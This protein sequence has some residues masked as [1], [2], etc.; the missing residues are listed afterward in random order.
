MDDR[1]QTPRRQGERRQFREEAGRRDPE[2]V[3]RRRRLGQYVLPAF[4]LLLPLALGAAYRFEVVI[5]RAERA[6][7][8][9]EV[10]EEV[11]SVLAATHFPGLSFPGAGSPAP[12]PP[13]SLQLTVPHEARVDFSRLCSKIP[14]ELDSVR[15]VPALGRTGALCALFLGDDVLERRRWERVAAFG[16]PEQSAE[17]RIG[18]S[19]LLVK[20]AV[21][22]PPGMDGSFSLD[23]AE[24]LLQ[25]ASAL[26]GE[27]EAIESNKEVIRK[28]RATLALQSSSP[29]GPDPT[30]HSL[31]SESD[32][33]SRHGCERMMRYYLE[34]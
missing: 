21:E 13:W 17:A 22:G 18:L 7:L 26:G 1:R 31:H 14:D 16:A 6:R 5:P 32:A 25:E 24:G 4:V 3:G 20:Q 34:S 11:R 33:A 15:E 2:R 29:E 30:W 10:A 27:S 12:V 23:R 19:L 9:G 28:L 8:A